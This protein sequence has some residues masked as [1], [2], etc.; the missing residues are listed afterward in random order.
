MSNRAQL[1][2]QT[3]H[4]SVDFGEKMC[5]KKKR[6]CRKCIQPFNIFE[7]AYNLKPLTFASF[8]QVYK[9]GGIYIIFAP[10]HSVKKRRF[11]TF[12]IVVYTVAGLH[13]VVFMY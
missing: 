12:L 3:L 7:S 10:N 6:D 1:A 2:I 5:V 4:S 8:P 9:R 11:V 13:A